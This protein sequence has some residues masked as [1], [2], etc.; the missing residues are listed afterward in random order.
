MCVLVY[1]SNIIPIRTFYSR[2]L[3]RTILTYIFHLLGVIYLL[4][5]IKL[6]LKF[7]K[8]NNASEIT[9]NLLHS[10]TTQHRSNSPSIAIELPANTFNLI[11]IRAIDTVR[12]IR[13]L[14][15]ERKFVSTFQRTLR[16]YYS[17]PP[18]IYISQSIVS[19]KFL[20]RTTNSSLVT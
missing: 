12:I 3:L 17:S 13:E 6:Q 8:N 7:Y 9:S 15:S 11:K 10:R 1:Y 18:D 16:I 5:D 14:S 20:P 19:W 4:I 2:T